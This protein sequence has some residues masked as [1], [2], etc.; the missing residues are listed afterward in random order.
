MDADAR[1]SDR[2]ADYARYRPSYP[3]QAVDFVLRELGFTSG[4]TVA[5][6][7]SGTGIFSA[8]LL[9]RGVRV[10][11]V[12]PN[13]PMREAAERALAGRDG[14][15]SHDGRAERTGLPDRSVD[16]VVAAQAFHWFDPAGARAECERILRPRGASANVAL[17]WNARRQ[18]GTPFLDGYE[19]LLLDDSV[20]YATV[21]HQDI[22]SPDALR[23]FF[24]RTPERWST[25]SVQVLDWDG[26]AGRAASSS[27]VP[28]PGHPRHAAFFA[29]L[30]ALFDRTSEA[31][32]V[33]LEYDVDVL[34][35]RLA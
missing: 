31:G 3:R 33:R 2:V 5:D 29:A 17:L 34:H 15:S 22:A 23:C 7:G 4:S 30:R 12:E 27:Y 18:S 16:A 24:G 6:L 14:F 28:A 20:D 9:D 11:S 19:Q 21:R 10:C 8:L 35:G 32:V 25:P 1:F 13:G 26:L